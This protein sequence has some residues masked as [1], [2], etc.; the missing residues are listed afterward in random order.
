M[1]KNKL[2]KI[3]LNV[4]ENEIEIESIIDHSV[5]KVINIT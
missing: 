1:Q 5:G 4:N 3:H 2:F